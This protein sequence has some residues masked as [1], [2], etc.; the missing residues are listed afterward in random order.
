VAS[1][2]AAILAQPL[3]PL[4]VTVAVLKGHA[5]PAAL[6]GSLVGWQLGKKQQLS[7]DPTR[8]SKDELL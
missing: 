4:F 1:I 5:L 2:Q 7:L 6:L 8:V 3:V